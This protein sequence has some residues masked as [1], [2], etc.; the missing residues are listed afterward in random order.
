MSYFMSFFE[1]LIF[2]NIFEKAAFFAKNAF[3]LLYRVC[4]SFSKACIGLPDSFVDSSEQLG[5][6]IIL[7]S[8][9]M[10]FFE[11]LIIGNIFEKA[12]FFAKNAFL[13]LY[14]VRKLF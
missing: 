2:G 5:G 14:R 1:T 6:I 8:Y 9:F 7:C 12:Y 4:K 13:L 3:L 10:S 11:T